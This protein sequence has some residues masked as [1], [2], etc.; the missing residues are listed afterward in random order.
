MFPGVGLRS[1]KRI[2]L[3]LLIRNTRL[4]LNVFILEVVTCVLGCFN[5]NPGRSR[6]LRFN[7]NEGFSVL[8]TIRLCICQ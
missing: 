1:A 7:F 2:A 6:F 3:S 8:S 4:N 5:R